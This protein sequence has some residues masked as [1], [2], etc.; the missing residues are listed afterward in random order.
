MKKLILILALILSVSVHAAET[1][2]ALLGRV[3]AK[4]ENAGSVTAGFSMNVAGE[5]S[6]GTLT[7]SGKK[8]VVKTPQLTTW[9][10]GKTQWAYSPSTGEVNITEPTPEE[11]AQINPVAIIG[12]FRKG[13]TAAYAKAPAGKKTVVLT[14]KAK[15]PEIK[16]ATVTLDAAT[17]Y[18]SIITLVMANGQKVSITVSA[19]KVGKALPASTFTFNKKQYPKAQIIDLR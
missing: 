9:F 18:P 17:L 5:K 2:D 13:F 7:L 15:K 12:A 14:A 3:V 8:F 1:A 4:L 6:S 10:D 19:V 16:S 11:L